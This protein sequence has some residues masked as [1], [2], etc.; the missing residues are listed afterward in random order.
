MRDL[1]A[2]GEL[3][4]RLHTDTDDDEIALHLA[5]V[6]GAD[7][8][9]RRRS[10]ERLDGGAQQ[11]LHAVVGMD[12]PVDPA[13]LG[14]DPPGADHDDLA[15]AVQPLAQHVGVPDATQVQDPV[16]FAAPP[17]LHKHHYRHNCLR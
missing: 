10:F 4:T 15:A 9:H 14:T 13:D 2:R 7:P 3:G 1:R 17:N 12:V 16:K 6:V 8:L 11:H 5:T